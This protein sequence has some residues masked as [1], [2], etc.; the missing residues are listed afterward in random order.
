MTIYTPEEAVSSNLL[1]YSTALNDPPD[2]YT[3]SSMLTACIHSGDFQGTKLTC[4]RS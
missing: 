4:H 3:E 2:Y 1:L